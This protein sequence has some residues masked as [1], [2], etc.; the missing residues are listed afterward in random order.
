M[1]VRDDH[2]DAD[3]HEAAE[4]IDVVADKDGVLKRDSEV[5]GD[6]SQSTGLVRQ[7]LVTGQSELVAPPGD[8]RVDFGRKDH[9]G[10]SSL[11]EPGY[12]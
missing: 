9:C 2:W 3:Q 7:P 6:L 12:A 5:R 1:G 8:D 4:V 10:D 11:P